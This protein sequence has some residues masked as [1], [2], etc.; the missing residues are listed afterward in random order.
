MVFNN[1][2]FNSLNC[3]FSV[4]FLFSI[5]LF[6]ISLLL[7]LFYLLKSFSTLSFIKNFGKFF[8]ILSITYVFFYFFVFNTVIPLFFLQIFAFFLFI[9]S[10]FIFLISYSSFI[11]VNFIFFNFYFFYICFF[12]NFSNFLFLVNVYLIKFFYFINLLNKHSYFVLKIKLLVENTYNYLILL[13][14]DKT[15]FL[16]FKDLLSFLFDFKTGTSQILNIFGLDFLNSIIVILLT[17]HIKLAS[18][19][20]N[21]SQYYLINLFIMFFIYYLVILYVMWGILGSQEYNNIKIFRRRFD[22]LFSKSSNFN[23]SVPETEFFDYDNDDIHYDSFFQS[24]SLMFSNFIPQFLV[25]GII[26]EREKRHNFEKYKNKFFNLEG[27]LNAQ[28]YFPHMSSEFLDSVIASKPSK[29]FYTHF[30]HDPLLSF[31]S[32]NEVSSV[33]PSGNDLLWKV[34]NVNWPSAWSN[35]NKFMYHYWLNY[36]FSSNIFFR[37]SEFSFST[38]LSSQDSELFFPVNFFIVPRFSPSFYGFNDTFDSKPALASIDPFLIKIN[39]NY[40]SQL[41]YKYILSYSRKDRNNWKNSGFSYKKDYNWNFWDYIRLVY[42]I[43]TALPY[44]SKLVSS[45]YD[46]FFFNFLSQRFHNFIK[47]KEINWTNFPNYRRL[48]FFIFPETMPLKDKLPLEL[49]IYLFRYRSSYTNLLCYASRDSCNFLS[50]ETLGIVFDLE[51]DVT[52]KD[53]GLIRFLKDYEFNSN[54]T[55]NFINRFFNLTSNDLIANYFLNDKNWFFCDNEYVIVKD[56]LRYGPYI[57]YLNNSFSK[58]YLLKD[59]DIDFSTNLSDVLSVS[60]YINDIWRISKNNSIKFSSYNLHIFNS[61]ISILFPYKNLY[62]RGFTYSTGSGSY[63]STHTGILENFSFSDEL[64]KNSLF[65]FFFSNIIEDIQ[66]YRKDWYSLIFNANFPYSNLNVEFLNRYKPDPQFLYEYYG[67]RAEFNIQLREPGFGFHSYMDTGHLGYGERTMFSYKLQSNTLLAGGHEFTSIRFYVL[68]APVFLYLCGLIKI[69]LFFIVPVF[70]FF[71][72]F[73]YFLNGTYSF[74]WKPEFSVQNQLT[75]GFTG[76]L[77]LEDVSYLDTFL[78]DSGFEEHTYSYVEGPLR[79]RK[80]NMHGYK[81]PSPRHW[82]NVHT[83]HMNFYKSTNYVEYGGEL[84]FYNYL[85]NYKNSIL[86]AR[87]KIMLEGLNFNDT[88]RGYVG[89]LHNFLS[90]PIYPDGFFD[91]DE[92]VFWSKTNSHARL[93]GS[94]RSGN[95][96][97][98]NFMYGDYGRKGIYNAL[99]HQIFRTK[100][101]TRSEGQEPFGFF[102]W[103]ISQNTLLRHYPVSRAVPFHH[104]GYF[105]GRNRLMFRT[106]FRQQDYFATPPFTHFNDIVSYKR[107]HMLHTNDNWKQLFISYFFWIKRYYLQVFLYLLF[108]FFFIILLLF[109]FLFYFF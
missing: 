27:L 77:K 34:A 28:T 52:F 31:L 55:S 40:K 39:R 89:P 90:Q 73:F 101:D 32:F 78:C 79:T 42:K 72:I 36:E 17:L 80:I 102:D 85:N 26:N 44:D 105:M 76:W 59:F 18:W 5:F 33:S 43:R 60:S 93:F 14:S 12:L 54:Y 48:P 21:Y 51:D 57:T 75:P 45:D 23:F 95:K 7:L 1:I 99:V 106:K 37:N 100:W 25:Y 11:V 62:N 98:R 46:F 67:Y 69:N 70:L 24:I 94:A 53:P 96:R 84:N 71:S 107:R 2:F 65:S 8:L 91:S 87:N 82:N 63:Y 47:S 109:L 6:S 58:N 108:K 41:F 35:T 30:H 10:L 29:I 20:E 81:S 88:V 92:G 16:S 4:F 86:K 49:P 66:N 64:N 61:I 68:Y 22:T 3:F 13:L 38:K 50:R 15:I 56:K 74:W 103:L 9:G 83:L 104:E 19:F 97:V